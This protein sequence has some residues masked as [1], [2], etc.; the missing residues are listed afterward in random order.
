[1]KK[2]NSRR[3]DRPVALTILLLFLFAGC[4]NEYN[5]ATEQEEKIMYGTDREVQLGDA[6]SQKVEEKYK[7]IKDVDI[8]ERVQKVLNRIVEVCDRKDLVYFAKVLDDD[9]MNAVSLPGGYV[10]IFRGLYDKI[11]N[12]DQLAGIIGHEVGHINA[13]HAVKRLQDSYGYMLIQAAAIGTGSGRFASGVNFALTSLFMAFSQEDELQAD[14]LGVKYMKKA[15]YDPKE[16]VKV[17]EILRKNQEKEP[18]R[19]Y[20]YWQT[21]PH[22]PQRIAAVNQEINGELQ[23]KDYLQLMDTQQ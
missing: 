13:K 22:I 23:F 3:G 21:H 7:V 5:L 4:T 2:R 15:G 6:I 1:M 20:S 8:N 14:K 11:Q 17:L 19:P 12:D 9:E 16:M 10:Y 18:L